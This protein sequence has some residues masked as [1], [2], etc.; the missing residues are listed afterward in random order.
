MGGITCCLSQKACRLYTRVFVFMYIVLLTYLTVTVADTLD[1][2]NDDMVLFLGVRL[3][4]YWCLLFFFFC[5][6]NFKFLGISTSAAHQYLGEMY[7]GILP[8]WNR[9][10]G[11]SLHD[12]SIVY[13]SEQSLEGQG[14]QMDSTKT[15]QAL[16]CTNR[17]TN[18]CH[19]S[20]EELCMLGVPVTILVS[21]P[22]LV[23]S[24]KSQFRPE[25]HDH[26]VVALDRNL[27]RTMQYA[28]DAAISFKSNTRL[29]CLC[30]GV[31]ATN[32]LTL[33]DDR[34]DDTAHFSRVFLL[35]SKG[36]L[37]WYGRPNVCANDVCKWH[38]FT[39]EVRYASYLNQTT[40]DETGKSSFTSR[41]FPLP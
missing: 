1:P 26:V 15:T 17:W 11:R 41:R 6:Y 8:F 36:R 13:A 31:G 14:I 27:T 3:C 37:A 38:S 7:R 30:V 10:V 22:N 5:A 23:V 24:L 4:A 2:V 35:D 39:D 29:K 9:S 18:D 16:L 19:T 32:A 20:L 28:E 40:L 33:L 34:L 12:L 21:R 25:P